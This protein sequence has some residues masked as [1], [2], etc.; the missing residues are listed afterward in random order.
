MHMTEG[1]IKTSK[2][3]IIAIFREELCKRT[4]IEI[5][6]NNTSIIAP[7]T[8]VRFPELH[9]LTHRKIPSK[10]TTTLAPTSDT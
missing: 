8:R 4:E 1:T 5:F 6:F 2:Y 10:H 3:E 7:H 9:I